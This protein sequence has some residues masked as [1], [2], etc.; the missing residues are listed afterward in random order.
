[1]PRSKTRVCKTAGPVESEMSHRLLTRATLSREMRAKKIASSAEGC[2]ERWCWSQERLAV[3]MVAMR[4]ST[5]AAIEAGVCSCGWLD[6][7]PRKTV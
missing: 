3:A 7:R 4:V 6:L 2:S 5:S 1:M